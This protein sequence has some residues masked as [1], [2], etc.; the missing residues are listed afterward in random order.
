[1]AKK[2][3]DG[4]VTLQEANR[5]YMKNNRETEKQ[6]NSTQN[7]VHRAID[8]TFGRLKNQGGAV[9]M[10]K[11]LRSVTE[12]NPEAPKGELTA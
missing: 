5:D 3:P 12:Q 9:R 4:C 2:E 6:L 10:Q 8:V 1:M 7:A 11:S